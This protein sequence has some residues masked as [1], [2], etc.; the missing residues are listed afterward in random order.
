M[1][2]SVFIKKTG[3][4]IVT[5]MLILTMLAAVIPIYGL[6]VK[7]SDTA[8]ADAVANQL[9]LLDFNI[10]DLTLEG[11]TAGKQY[12]GQYSGEL[13]GKE[14][15][16]TVAADARNIVSGNGVEINLGTPN[17]GNKS[18]FRVEITKDN[19]IQVRNMVGTWSQDEN[20]TYGGRIGMNQSLTT[21]GIQPGKSFELCMKLTY[22]DADNDGAEDD[23]RLDLYVNGTQ[24]YGQQKV[25]ADPKITVNGLV[26]RNAVSILG[27][28]MGFGVPAG[29]TLKV[30]SLYKAPTVSVEDF[31][32][33][34][35][36]P[37][38]VAL[39]G[40]TAAA[41]CIGTYTGDSLAGKRFQANVTPSI[42]GTGKISH[43]Y[44]AGKNSSGWDGF[45]IRLRVHPTS[46]HYILE[47]F[48][49]LVN[50]GSGSAL[51][52]I[53]LTDLNLTEKDT[54]FLELQLDLIDADGDGA[55]DDARLTAR[56]NHR[57]QGVAVVNDA[58]EKLG[59]TMFLYTEAGQALYLEKVLAKN[60][61][62]EITQE[63]KIL[64]LNTTKTTAKTVR[65]NSTDTL[66]A[67]GWGLNTYGYCGTDSGVYYNG[68]LNTKI[69]FR[70]I[71]DGGT[72]E[73]YLFLADAGITPA[74]NDTITIRGA[75]K[76]YTKTSSVKFHETTLTF[77][78][79]A[80]KQGKFAA[81]EENVLLLQST[82]TQGTAGIYLTG[83]D[84][85]PVGGWVPPNAEALPGENNGVFYYNAAAGSTVKTEV[86][87]RKV[88]SGVWYVCLLDKGVKPTAGDRITLKGQF[89][90]NGY[91]IEFSEI[92]MTYDGTD[93]YAWKAKGTGTPG[94]ANA[95]AVVDVRD[96]IRMKRYTGLSK[97][98]MDDSDMNTDGQINEADVSLLKQLL[99]GKIEFSG[100]ANITGLP[101]YSLSEAVIP[102]GAYAGPRKAGAEYWGTASDRVS[103]N[104]SYVTEAGFRDYADAGFNFV[105]AEHDGVYENTEEMDTY[106]KAAA[107]QGIN[108]YAFSSTLTRMLRSTDGLTAQDKNFLDTLVRDLS[109]Y[110]NF[111]GLMMADEPLY[112]Q[113]DKYTVTAEYLRSLKPELDLFTSGYSMYVS[114]KAFSDDENA[115]LKKVYSAYADKLGNAL[116][117]F[118]YDFYSFREDVNVSTSPAEI[119]NQ[120]VRSEWFQNLEMAASAAKGKYDTGI[121]VQSH[122]T[123]NP[124]PGEN[125]TAY[126]NPTK[127]DISFQVY[128]A[129]AY[130]MKQITYYTYWEHF[131]QSN[132][133]KF[134]TAMIMWE[135]YWDPDS[136]PYKTELYYGV[137]EVN[138]EILAFD[139][140]FMNFNWQGTVA[141]KGAD[142]D[143]MLAKISP[144]SAPRIQALTGDNDVI[145]GCL[146]D[147]NAY[148]GFMMV[149]ATDPY[150]NKTA[151]GTVTFR[152]A[153]NAVV[154]I[155]GQAQTVTLDQG[156]YN[157]TLTPGEGVFVIPY[158]MDENE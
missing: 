18:G 99:I 29:T 129:L 8:N 91:I 85:A 119:T 15:I 53:D 68:K 128:S 48:D 75:F 154:Y 70:K 131:A 40:G 23:A 42:D 117:N 157:Y 61:V 87:L 16:M 123:R 89:H 11:G 115:D 112:S 71:T 142:S 135:D 111:K 121:T 65:F 5:L 14:V 110:D 55:K 19:C 137:Q 24:I 95:D 104:N 27:S 143:G 44:F 39:G 109:E 114:K 113:L 31:A 25:S 153:T 148:E 30:N 151:S 26:V 140:V 38:R 105:F 63:R 83:L 43:L 1:K 149:N 72:T 82:K 124:N 69:A 74:A 152:D 67:G 118:C 76:I 13:N 90:Y 92:S 106:M 64:T 12:N 103:R 7:A 116:K 66:E 2:K 156:V 78:G 108:V 84:E 77:D 81:D 22:L 32:G 146:K 9:T 4:R 17:N 52:T 120:S 145:I 94:D 102:L 73:W 158:I 20:P 127:N 79:T 54:F 107:S 86:F 93:T 88:E 60:E 58:K 100:G 122:G 35:F 28:Y 21:L 47:I 126:R 147:Q 3:K 6:V 133:G 36:T 50:T 132:V 41:S 80:W 51:S 98:S 155:H 57:R 101:D 125:Y 150:D 96:L 59:N 134:S 144:Y 33:M 139:H 10:P 141:Y 136:K 45:W 49:R 138:R 56:V 97:V 37:Y 130:G 62:I 46:G 34:L